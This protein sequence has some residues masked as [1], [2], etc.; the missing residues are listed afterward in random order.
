MTSSAT[1]YVA[2]GECNIAKNM[3]EILCTW[4]IWSWDYRW[5]ILQSLIHKSKLLVGEHSCCHWTKNSLHPVALKCFPSN[6]L[7]SEPKFVF[8][9]F[10]MPRNIVIVSYGNEFL[11]HSY[12]SYPES[13]F[14]WAIKKNKYLFPNHLYC[15]LM[16][17][18]YATFRHS[19]HHCWG[20]WQGQVPLRKDVTDD[21]PTEV[22]Y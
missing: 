4:N 10:Q 3:L 17:M 13:K 2:A 12:I 22:I 14:R 7:A 11:C 20:T 16:Y 6:T 9:L 19:F 21:C 1:L 8:W 15:R 5:V 18:P